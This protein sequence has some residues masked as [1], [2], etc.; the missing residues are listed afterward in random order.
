MGE[1]EALVRVIETSEAEAE[2]AR[3]AV[4]ERLRTAG[5]SR[6]RIVTVWSRNS[7]ARRARARRQRIR[8]QASYAGGALLI[9]AV[10]AWSLW[11]LWI[12]AG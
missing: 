7:V 4:E 12:L 8:P 11:F 10:V 6:W 3:R 2:A 5:F 1:F 9:A